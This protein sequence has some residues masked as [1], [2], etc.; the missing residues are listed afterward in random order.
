MF[1]CYARKIYLNKNFN[2]YCLQST[3]KYIR[4]LTK[5]TKESKESTKIKAIVYYDKY[6]DKLMCKDADPNDS[7]F[8]KIICILSLISC[9]YYFINFIKYIRPNKIDKLLLT[10]N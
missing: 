8:K 2:D 3:L 4:G 6:G 9:T 5:E 1:N 10:N 7:Y